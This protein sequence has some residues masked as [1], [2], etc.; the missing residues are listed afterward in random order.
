MRPATLKV[1]TSS[2]G[3]IF[4][5][6]E[7]HIEIV[8]VTVR[9]GQVWCLP[10]GVIDKGEKPEETAIREVREEAGV[11]GNIIE[12]LGEITYWY[13][14]KEEHAKCKK[15]VHF[16]LMEYAEGDIS[17]HDQEVNDAFWVPLDEAVKKAQ[18]KGEREILEKAR[19][20]FRS[21]QIA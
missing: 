1:Q 14:I 8:M 12:K 11:R 13:Y 18:Y 15:T 7:D 6:E 16:F 10:K 17:D 19:K 20:L 21:G 9:G 4:R 3:V 5:R 2:G